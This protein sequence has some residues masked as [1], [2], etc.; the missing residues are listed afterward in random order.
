MKELLQTATG[1][2]VRSAL[3]GVAVDARDLPGAPDGMHDLD[4][5]LS[6]EPA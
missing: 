2:L 4:V 3:R 1:E 6:D 5:L